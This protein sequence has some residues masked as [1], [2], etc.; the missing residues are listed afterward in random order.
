[1]DK[2]NLYQFNMRL[3]RTH[4]NVTRVYISNYTNGEH[5]LFLSTHHSG[6]LRLAFY[7][8]FFFLQQHCGLGQTDQL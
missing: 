1:M 6:I 8:Y 4:T 2:F 7:L 5:M 3:P